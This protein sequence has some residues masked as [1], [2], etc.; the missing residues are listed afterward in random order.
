[1]I[2][3]SVKT[4][5]RQQAAEAA[6]ILNAL[7]AAVP[8]EIGEYDGGGWPPCHTLNERE[9]VMKLGEIAQRLARYPRGSEN[10]A[11]AA[12]YAADASACSALGHC[13]PEEV[14]LKAG[15]L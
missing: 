3:K 11:E 9:G 1:M 7:L 4:K 10:R 5:R 13:T 12:F 8:A 14:L 6:Q 2:S 15:L